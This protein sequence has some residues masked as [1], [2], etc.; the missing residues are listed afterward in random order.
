[1]KQKRLK[2][3]VWGVVTLALLLAYA[4]FLLYPLSNMFYMAF[5]D[6]KTGA[7]SLTNFVKFFSKSYYSST[8]LN[9]F[10]VSLAATCTTLLI[11][12]PMAYFFTLYKIRGKAVLK[13]LIIICCMSAPFV[14]AYSWIL[15]LGRNGVITNFLSNLMGIKAP[16]IYG[17]GGILLVFTSQLFP[18]IFLYV[19]GALKKMDNSLME[20]S[21][22]M[23]VKG[24]KRFVT[25]VLP[26]ILPTMMAG[27]LLVFV[28]AMSDFGTP[29]LIGEGYRTFTVVLYNEFV[30]EVSQSK[31]FASAIAMIAIGITLIVYLLQQYV[32]N[33]NAY[34]MNTLNPI[35]EK[36]LRGVKNVLIHLFCYGVIA[37]ALLPQVYVIYTSFQKTS[38][39]I[40][41]DGYSL[42]SYRSMFEKLGSSVRNT[43]IIPILSLIVI[44]VLAMLI[45]YISVRRRN[46]FSKA[47]DT[48][49]MIPYVIPGTV[50]GIALLS[51]FN[52]KPL[53]FSGTMFIMCMALVIR[54]L[55]YTIRSS[56]AILQQLPITVEEAAQSLG[57]S[58]AKTF[59][60]V[61]APMMS[62]GVVSGAILSWVTMIAELSTAIILYTGR[63]Q[64]LTVAIY[65]QIIRGNYGVA[66]AMA[67][68][69]TLL[70][71]ISLIIFSLVFKGKDISL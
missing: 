67:T 49:S 18:L 51:C 47:V 25:V 44:V 54:R 35:Q 50:L 70:I 5:T 32:S 30:G 56:S 59:F 62:S 9:S 60:K 53:M 11:G 13:I 26:L 24:L 40:F 48:I 23:G 8:L 15:L 66:A 58:K 33:K 12:T 42:D 4:L 3:D 10:K 1:M 2:M 7:L 36:K 68:V 16:N 52:K 31:G 71:V 19:Q 43:L 14:G 64:T 69:L 61:T 21:E 55:P 39:L 37:I 17:F 57:A 65:T 20:A 27:G 34:A 6:S 63:T 38:G 29:M 22:N 28:R 41:V 46:P 45:A